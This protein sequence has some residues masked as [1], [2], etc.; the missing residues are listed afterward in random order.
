MGVRFPLPGAARWLAAGLG[1]GIGVYAAWVALEWAKYGHPPAAADG[2]ADPLLDSV[3]PA[4]DVVE[5]QRIR[6]AAPPEVTLAAAREMDLLHLPLARLIFATRACVMGGARDTRPSGGLLADTLA[7][8][9]RVVAEDPGREIVVAA[10]TRPWD[11]DPVF[12]GLDLGDFR[13]DER[14][15]AVKIAWT[16]RVDPTAEGGAI[17]RTETR[18][19]ATDEAGRR[20]F[21]RYWALAAPGIRVIRRLS[22]A[23]LRADAERR[24]RSGLDTAAAPAAGAFA[25]Q[26]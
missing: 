18:A 14:A 12:E 7:L 16:L 21:R 17:F 22:L 25:G 15:E 10:I 4:Y 2:D 20:R 26:P 23:P 6:I 1:A 5:R 11:A 24:A 13:R 8:G 19:V 3:M 9:W